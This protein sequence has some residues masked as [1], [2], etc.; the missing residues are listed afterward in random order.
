MFFC[1]MLTAVL[2]V[3]AQVESCL[4]YRR[5]T[6]QDGLPQMQTERLFQDSRGYIYIGT[7][8]GFVR[9]DGCTFT[10]F[11]KGKRF[12]IVGFAE[13]DDRVWAL[14]FRQR[15]LIGQDNVEQ[16]R[17][18]AEGHWLLNN[19][20]SVHLPNGYILLED[21]QEQ[22]R[23]LAKLDKQA[24]A[25]KF[26]RITTDK[27][28]NQMTP[29]RK[30][31]LDSSVV[32]IPTEAGIYRASVTAAAPA[33][34][35][36]SSDKIEGGAFSLCRWKGTLYAF[37]QDGIYT[38]GGDGVRMH[39]P[40]DKWQTGYGLIVRDAGGELLIADEHSLYSFDGH[41]VRKLI[42]G[43]NLI[44]DMLIDRWGRLW[45]TTYQGL[46]C[47]FNRHFTNHAL[48]DGD[49]IVRA[50]AVNGAGQMV[51]GTLNGK[52]IVGGKTVYDE[53]DNFFIPS[54]ATIEGKVYLAGRSDMACISDSSVTWLGLPFERYQFIT[55]A[56]GRI[57]VGTRQLVCTYDPQTGVIDTL[58][59]DIQHPWCAAADGDGRLW[60]GST[61]GLYCI[62]AS[63]TRKTSSPGDTSS[64]SS[65]RNAGVSK[66]GYG[67]QKLIVTTMESDGKGSVY[68]AS[69]DS[70]FVISRGKVEELNS[71]LPQLSGHE[72]RALHVSPRGYLVV[73]AI[74]GL[75]VCRLSDSHHISK[76]CFFNHLNGFTLLEP[77]KA[78]LAEQPDGTVWLCSVEQMASFQPEEL[79][80]DA[81]ADTFIAPPLRW[82]QHWWVWLIA[83]LLLTAAVWILAR[84]LEKRRSR[85]KMMRLHQEKV[86]RE[87]LIQ[88]IRQEAMKADNTELGKDIVK[89]TD[90][91]EEKQRLTLRT[92]NGRIMVDIANIV[93]LKAEGNYTQLVTFYSSDMVMTG[94]GALTK[95][96]DR[97]NFVRADRSTLVNTQFICRLNVNERTCHFRSPD[98]Q[99]LETTLLAPAFKRLEGLLL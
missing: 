73:A 16:Q 33:V 63:A 83:A 66:Q 69:G 45:V 64:S 98:G 82:W 43:A 76:A 48:A 20:N 26:S 85:R 39:T 7:L 31:Y 59:T 52:I 80:A 10:P 46:Y 96:L 72:V 14:S 65:T 9:F 27:T 30:L 56:R 6:T 37:A 13:T 15:W 47:F 71:E 36:P 28:L 67:N 25:P 44:K 8:S 53:A 17:L 4:S 1:L 34:I 40:Y 55:E 77:L 90:K 91:A 84:W 62:E 29:D 99:E 97:P 21:E 61:F 24:D 92:A 49:D 38:I 32:Y 3:H 5:Y 54:S 42:G 60:V 58:T 93:F 41:D 75:F 94:I 23:W 22:N 18:D 50:V 81:Q 12:S 78:R 79:V 51:M 87:Q 11:L 88:A 19:F 68:F 95:M 35:V 70:L 89:M 57:V 86:E 74:D 2:V